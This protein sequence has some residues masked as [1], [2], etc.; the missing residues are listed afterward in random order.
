MPLPAAPSPSL[1]FDLF[2]HF[3]GRPEDLSNT[4]EL[5]DAIPKYAFRSRAQPGGLSADAPPPVYEQTFSWQPL[6]KSENAPLHCQVT[7]T[8]A[9][10]ETATGWIDVFPGADEELVEEVLRKIFADQDY[11]IHDAGGGKSFVRFTLRHIYRELAARNKTRS[12]A[13]IARSLQILN[14]C[15]ITVRVGGPGRGKALCQGPVLPT[16]IARSRSDFLEDPAAVWAAQMHPLITEAI[17]RLSYRQFNYATLMSLATPLARWLLKRLSHEYIN[18]DLLT[19]YHTTLSSIERDSGLLKHSRTNAN[20][21]TLLRALDELKARG[22]LLDTQANKEM[23][24]RSIV[25]LALKLTPTSRFVAEVKAANARAS[26]HDQR[27]LASGHSGPWQDRALA[28]RGKATP[29][30]GGRR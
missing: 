16:L 9:R 12:I 13:E 4:I 6:P 23:S 18:A 17:G 7:L 5:W 21:A 8:P 2:T 3:F 26:H 15:S 30:L 25:D 27:M 22:V 19:P 29:A 10:I 11:G 24:G 28:R 14:K 1:Q 20:I